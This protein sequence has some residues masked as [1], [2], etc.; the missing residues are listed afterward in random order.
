[1]PR[2][3]ARPRGHVL[4]VEDNPANQVLAVRLLDRLGYSADV[5]VN[6][7]EAVEATGRRAY[8]AV[9]MD[10]HMPELD[11]YQA[12]AEI[13]R[14]EGTAAHTPIIALTA[15]VLAEERNRCL[16][17]GMD[18]YLVKPVNVDDVRDALDRWVGGRSDPTTDP[19][20][21]GEADDSSPLLTQLVA[22]FLASVPG[23]IARLRAALAREDAAA[24]QQVAHYIKGGT[25]TFGLHRMAASCQALELLAESGAHWE[26]GELVDRLGE[27]L[28]A[29]QR[30]VDGAMRGAG[31]DA[32][33]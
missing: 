16:A 28:A 8:G 25:V 23:D 3:G 19:T 9:L 4:V 11:G 22:A 33:G 6:G 10:C 20:E 5:A 21:H 2:P 17:S 18:D 30:A 26:A 24:V 31:D 15:G 14:R 13:R 1:M 32:G 7:R 27:D 12:T 29:A